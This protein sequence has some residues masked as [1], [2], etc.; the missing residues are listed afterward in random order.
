MK[1]RWL[2]RYM[3]AARLAASWSK[4]PSTG[5]GC[6][7]V[8]PDYLPVSEGFNG[9]PRSWEHDDAYLHHRADKYSAI[10]HAELNAILFARQDLTGCLMITYPL[11]P[12]SRCAAVIRQSGIAEVHSPDL[13]WA[14]Q[15]EQERLH[16]AMRFDLTLKIFSNRVNIH[17]YDRRTFAELTLEEAKL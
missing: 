3:E 13:G 11:P 10:I 1:R 4:D 9:F 8:T 7:I 16:R 6:R 2:K 17:L 12:C 5:V 14:S 15:S